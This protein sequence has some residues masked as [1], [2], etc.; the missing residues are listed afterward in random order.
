[1]VDHCAT[2]CTFI[3][4]S[5]AETRPYARCLHNPPDRLSFSKK[6]NINKKHNDNNK[7]TLKRLCD[8]LEV[9]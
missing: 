7:K 1:M 4:A 9:Q 2:I 3:L 8:P 6:L 5:P